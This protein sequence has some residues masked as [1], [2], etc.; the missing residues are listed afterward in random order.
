MKTT[1]S[2]TLGRKLGGGFGLVCLLLLAVVLVAA[3]QLRAMQS[4]LQEVVEVNNRQ[5]LQAQTLMQDVNSIGQS[6]RDMALLQINKDLDEE[7]AS[8]KSSF[9]H[10][11]EVERALSSAEGRTADEDRIFAAMKAVRTKVQPAIMEAAAL[12]QDG[13]TPE[14]ANMITSTIRPSLREWRSHVQALV[15][16]K[17]TR[18]ETQFQSA[19]AQQASA[20]VLLWTIG[21]LAI[22]VS[23]VCAI[24]LPRSVTRPLTEAIEVA[25]RIAEGDLSSKLDTRRGDEIGQLLRSIARMQSGL[26]KLVTQVRSSAN[27]IATASQEIAT[28]NH[29]LSIRTE[30]TASNLQETAQSMEVLT[31]TV[32]QSAEAAQQANRLAGSAS[33]VAARGGSMIG[34]V[35]NTMG[36]INQSSRQIADI[37]SVIDGIAFQTNILAL[38]AAVEAA[39]AGEQGRG[40]A[41]VASEVR[42]LAQRSAQAAKEIKGLIDKSVSQVSAGSDLVERTGSTMQDIVGAVQNVNNMIGDITMAAS[43]QSDGIGNVNASVSQL[44]QMTQQN[45]ALVEQSAAAASSLQ[46]QAAKLAEVIRVFQLGD[47]PSSLSMPA[48]SARIARER[49]ALPR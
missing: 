45:A 5:M 40:F 20:T 18:N 24:V 7:M 22:L 34:D 1:T 10:Y 31:A 13:A 16:L 2:L 33:E 23:V 47:E 28:G 36:A 37:T 42:S 30:Q 3:W 4:T 32:K 19:Q 6:I 14:A 44:D 9:A 38:N 48:P 41:V 26:H 21:L 25:E 12:G 46:E 27:S 35:V 43:E 39:R 8:L 15:T 11:D 29:D 49:L 17:T